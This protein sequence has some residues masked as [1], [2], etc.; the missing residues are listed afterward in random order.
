MGFAS[1]RN[2]CCAAPTWQPAWRDATDRIDQSNRNARVY[3]CYPVRTGWVINDKYCTARGEERF[4]LYMS[5]STAVVDVGFFIETIWFT[6]CCCKSCNIRPR[7]CGQPCI[8]V[9]RTALA[10]DSFVPL[11]AIDSPCLPWH[12]CVQRRL[13]QV[14]VPVF[15]SRCAD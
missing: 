7:F 5:N 8:R 13:Y 12:C 11:P 2:A 14:E 10:E 3:C 4:R 1:T 9:A 6:F 15:L